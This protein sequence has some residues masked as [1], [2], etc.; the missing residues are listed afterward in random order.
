M[1]RILPLLA[2]AVVVLAFGLLRGLATDRWGTAR[3]PAAS[4]EKLPSV[5]P[6]ALDDDWLGKDTEPISNQE[7]AIGRIAGYVSRMYTNRRTGASV[8]VLLVCGRP[9]PIGVHTPDVCFAGAGY[10]LRS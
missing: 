4:A 6:L 8:A 7:L 9:G 1:Y 2:G 5:V 3:E 10:E